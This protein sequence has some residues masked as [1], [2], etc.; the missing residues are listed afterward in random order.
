MSDDVRA[1]ALRTLGRVPISEVVLSCG[2]ADVA[3]WL[4]AQG[5][6]H[7]AVKTELRGYGFDDARYFADIMRNGPEGARQHAEAEAGRAGDAIA[8]DA[9]YADDPAAWHTV[10]SEVARSLARTILRH[11]RAG[12]RDAAKAVRRLLPERLE[13]RR[14]TG[15]LTDRDRRLIAEA[16]NLA[17]AARKLIEQ[18][19]VS[20]FSEGA[21]M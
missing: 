11:R 17:A 7:Y 4:Y 12:N 14:W 2:A 13:W 1:S 21:D 8:P 6:D 10:W 20:S 3:L 18:G 19:G 9:P 5:Y 16:E 15:T